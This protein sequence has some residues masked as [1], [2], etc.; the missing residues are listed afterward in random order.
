MVDPIS[1][2]SKILFQSQRNRFSPPTGEPNASASDSEDTSA[3]T[4]ESLLTAVRNQANT[5]KKELPALISQALLAPTNNAS[6]R[7]EPLNLLLFKLENP[8]DSLIGRLSE[9]DLTQGLVANLQSEVSQLK[10][11]LPSLK[12]NY[13]LSDFSSNAEFSGP[14]Q[15]ILSAL[16]GQLDGLDYRLGQALANKLT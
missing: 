5:V 4:G 6:V 1:D 13:L 8:L 12:D 3:F 15:D 11:E 7:S 2:L 9:E 16:S 14:L 10:N